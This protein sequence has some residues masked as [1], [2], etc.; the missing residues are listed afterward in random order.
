MKIIH[1]NQNFVVMMQINAKVKINASKAKVWEVLT[2]NKFVEQFM[3]DCK[4]ESDWKEGSD[5]NYYQEKEGIKTYMV[6]GK[7]KKINEPNLLHHSLFPANATYVNLPENHI[8]VI[9][10]LNT[11][12]GGTELSVEQGGYSTVED[13]K[14][15]YESSVGGWDYLFP[16]IKELAEGK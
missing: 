4:I 2:Q 13:G 8:Y 6:L 7:I 15:R 12:E 10:L 3:F 1:L 5:L 9:Y 16:K 14:A 11:V